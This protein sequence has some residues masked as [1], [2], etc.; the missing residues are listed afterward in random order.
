MY[1]FKNFTKLN[2]FL[3]YVSG[4]ISTFSIPPFSFLPLIFCIGFGIYTINFT[5]KLLKTFIGAWFLGFGWFS[6]G[7]YW[8]GSAFIVADKYHIF[9]M[10][11][12]II[13]LPSFLALFWGCACVIAKLLTKDK[14]LSIINMIIFLSLFEYLR[15]K[16]F[17]G[18]PWL[19]PSIVLSSNENLIQIFSFIGSFS[20]NLVVFSICVLPFILFSNFKGK[21]F[22][23]TSLLV[24]VLILFFCGAFRYQ[25]KTDLKI[26]DQFITLVQPNIE[27]INKWNLNKRDQNLKKLIELSINNAD[28]YENKNR[29][30]I[31]PETSFEGSI[32]NE[33]KLLSSISKQVIKSPKTILVV[34]LLRT[35]KG[36]IFNSLVFLN[37]EG[38]ILYQYDKI[39]LVPFGEYIPF[40][41]HLKPISDFLSSTDFTSGKILSNPNLDGFGNI[42][43]LICYEILFTEEINKRISKKTNLLINI[44]NDAW[45]GK[46]IG[47]YQH[48]ALAK[49]KAVEFGLPLARVA[50]TGI[51]AYISSF[52]E[53][54]N[55]IPLYMEDVQTFNLTSKLDYTL[56]KLYGEYIFIVL[57]LILLIINKIYN[58]IYKEN[59]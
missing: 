40:R 32:P 38:K 8:I 45:F 17:T 12:A 11:I 7:L 44:T 57:I 52:G 53:V 30:I 51:S 4:A 46:T 43:S 23:F 49:I 6:F 25:N 41:E 31:W 10:P 16:I 56:Y 20:S 37:F 39:K 59:L 9:M 42:I 14:T 18:F 33:M 26:K 24:P 28:L 50:N 47:P 36:K 19:M 15:A 34:G 3:I 27:Q 22:V 58:F 2:Y 5:S 48:L 21:Y 54:V 29:I 1:R 13:L 35:E 55:K